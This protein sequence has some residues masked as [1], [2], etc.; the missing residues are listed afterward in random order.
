[1]TFSLGSETGSS[2][3][4][5]SVAEFSNV[6]WDAVLRSEVAAS[7]PDGLPPIEPSP[8]AT[9]QPTETV[10]ASA[11]AV[12]PTKSEM[13]RESIV[14]T[15]SPARASDVGCVPLALSIAES[16][17]TLQAPEVAAASKSVGLRG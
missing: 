3:T 5:T 7:E 16:D 8:E 15:P 10:A 2:S 4:S 1:M 12:K 11:S 13:R 6:F 9:S 17:A 14:R